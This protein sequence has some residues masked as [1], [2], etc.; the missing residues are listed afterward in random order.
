MVVD[1]TEMHSPISHILLFDI[2]IISYNTFS[3]FGNNENILIHDK[4]QTYGNISLTNKEHHFYFNRI[5]H[6]LKFNPNH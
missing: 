1:Y 2:Q 6:L 5:S 4:N 3:F